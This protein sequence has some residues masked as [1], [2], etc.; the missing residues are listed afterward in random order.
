MITIP[1]SLAPNQL[2]TKCDPDDIQLSSAEESTFQSDS[3]GQERAIEAIR[4]A[5]GIKRHGYN[6]FAYGASG[7]AKHA[8]VRQ[9]LE[10][11]AAAMPI[12]PDWCYVHNFGEPHRPTALRLP[13]GRGRQL[14]AEME[15]LID[16][17]RSAIPAAFEREEY[18]ARVKALQA[19]YGERYE[20]AFNELQ[21]R[22]KAKNIALI[23]TPAGLAL[24]PASKGEVISTEAFRQWPEELQTKIKADIAELEEELR[25]FLQ[26]LPRW[27]HKQRE[28]LRML[29]QEVTS[30]AVSHLIEELSGKYNDLEDV[31]EYIEQV[32]ADLLENAGDFHE[33][34]PH[35]PQE[36]LALALRGRSAKPSFRRY[37]V[38]L[39]VDNADRERAPIVYEDLPTHTNIV[40]RIEQ[41]AEFGALMTDFNLIKPGALHAANGG[42]LLIDVRKLFMQP[43][44]WEELKRAL[45]SSEIRI[46][47]LSEVLG[48]TSTVTL[49]PQPIPLDV[50]VV[51]LGDPR[52]Y[53]LLSRADPDLAKL[54]KVAADF[55]DQ[56]PRNSRNTA[57]YG[58]L[59]AN[60]TRRENLLP[61]D[62][63]ALARVI[64]RAARLTDD[65]ERLTL[66]VRSIA[67][68]LCEADYWANQNKRKEITAEDVAKAIDAQIRR[69]ARIRERSHEQILRETTLIDTDGE[70]V[71]QVNGLSVLQLGEFAFGKPSRITARVRP[72]RGEVLDIEREV[73]LGGPLHSKGVLILTSYLGA[74]FARHYPLA[75]SASLVFEQAYGGVD[76]D[77]ASSTEL[78]ALLSALSGLP[79][80]QSLAVTGSVSQHGQVQAIGGVNEKI[81]GFFDICKARGLTGHQGVLIP[82]S[83]VRHLM[84][85]GDVVDA[86]AQGKFHIYPIDVID[87]G[88]ELLTGVTA[89]E[90]DENGQ[91]PTE[92]VNGRVQATL[93]EFAETGRA[94]TGRDGSAGEGRP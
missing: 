47:G 66:R 19:Q 51:L 27:E 6:I 20:V 24:A 89:G 45:Y 79:V 90:I 54:F 58:Q 26:Q 36:T 72:G 87:Q 31:L 39:I 3:L 68:L 15:R 33:S 64:E 14:R 16:E 18:Q 13:A 2:Y 83:N 34:D 32:R 94:F 40:G 92:T 76:G 22:A 38:N 42:F 88:I 59:V 30:R 67:N 21:E 70:V 11:A 52:I 56:V 84:L 8:L 55:D 12:P 77:S 74:R 82:A 17:L 43:V 25:E 69:N 29:N 53:Y 44:I 85:H 37:Q 61:L 10:Q 46:Q 50:K 9:Q 5:V 23:R 71:G 62:K 80:R 91:F 65:S 28:Q 57:H 1:D 4:F 63:Y 35:S 41:M 7:T 78:Y 60:I 73:E 48:Y 93:R 49:Q 81:E 86:A 75:L